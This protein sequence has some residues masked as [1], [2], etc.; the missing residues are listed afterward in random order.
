MYYAKKNFYNLFLTT[1]IMFAI[2]G[3]SS[4]AI[5]SSKSELL[6][7][8][9]KDAIAR[10]YEN[11]FNVTASPNGVVQIKGQVNSLYDKLH[12]FDIAARVRGVKRIEDFVA[13]NAKIVP[14]NIIKSNLLE[15]LSL[16]HSILEPNRIKVAVDNGVIELRGTVSYY[17]EKLMA[18]TVASWQ[19]GALGIVNNISVLPP[20]LAVSDKNIRIILHDILKDS[21]PVESKVNFTVHDGIVN[22]TG[23][24]HTLWAKQHIE[25]EFRKVRGVKDVINKIN[26]AEEYS[27][28]S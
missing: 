21:F 17:R 10:Y 1:I 27:N 24:A 25:R 2:W 22:V 4:Q 13:V 16:V 20:K 28:I 6:A 3:I 23:Y 26:I 9:V 19:K 18:E 14:D 5:A 8:K 7:S 12:I 15:E 11:N